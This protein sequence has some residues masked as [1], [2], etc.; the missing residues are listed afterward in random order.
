MEQRHKDT[1][2][3]DWKFSNPR[4]V[5]CPGCSEC[6]VIIRT[7]KPLPG[8]KSRPYKLVCKHCGHNSIAGHTKPVTS[9]PLW[10]ETPFGNNT[11]YAYNP[12]HLSYLE[13]FVFAKRRERKP[14]DKWGWTNQSMISR[15]PAWIKS[16]KNREEILKAINKLWIKV[17]KEGLSR[18]SIK[19]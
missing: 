7:T 15:L 1:L 14:D 12:D 16:A 4:Y 3:S 6:A 5:V 17:E 11:L 10:L 9:F 8:Y 2:E 19:E 18:S 13:S